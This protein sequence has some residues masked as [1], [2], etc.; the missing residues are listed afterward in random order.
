MTSEFAEARMNLARALAL[1]LAPI[2]P[3][4]SWTEEHLTTYI[5]QLVEWIF[6]DGLEVDIPLD[7]T[8]V[9]AADWTLQTLQADVGEMTGAPWPP[10][11]I[12]P[13]PESERAGVGT[14]R[15][16]WAER[17]EGA[18]HLGF[19]EGQTAALTLEPIKLDELRG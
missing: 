12:A 15:H 8:L 14:N 9:R 7:A 16:P 2:T 3:I 11:R 6:A 1:R 18:I 10:S 4:D 19:G 17:R 13:W 5:E